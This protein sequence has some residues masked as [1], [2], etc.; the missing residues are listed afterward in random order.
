MQHTG[1]GLDLGLGW[2]VMTLLGHE[3]FKIG[4]Y[5]VIVTELPRS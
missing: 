5:L 4:M 2:A 1:L 3:C